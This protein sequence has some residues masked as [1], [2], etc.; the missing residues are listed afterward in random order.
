MSRR[1]LHN[2][3]LRFHRCLSIDTIRE[4]KED[5]NDVDAFA[6]AFES[7]PSTLTSCRVHSNCIRSMRSRRH[8]HRRQDKRTKRR[9]WPRFG[10]GFNFSLDFFFTFWAR[11]KEMKFVFRL[12]S[13][14]RKRRRTS[15]RILNAF[16]DKLNQI[17]SARCT[18]NRYAKSI[19]SSF[20]I[21]CF[22]LL[23]LCFD[24]NERVQLFVVAFCCFCTLRAVTFRCSPFRVDSQIHY[25]FASWRSIH[26]RSTENRQN[27][28]NLF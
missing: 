13:A 16:G 10:C 24:S 14:A 6:V 3:A 11:W 15:S 17:V 26:S 28:R 4:E 20:F 19:M 21:A 8:R 22:S 2:S 9:R 18:W 1:S 27:G 5:I 25:S 7:I 23:F 12:A